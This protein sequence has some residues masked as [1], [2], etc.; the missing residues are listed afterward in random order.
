M[1]WLGQAV[2]NRMAQPVSMGA[3]NQLYAATATDVKG[4]D[5]IGPK[6]KNEQSG[7]PHKAD[8]SVAAKNAADAKRLW[9]VSEKLTGINYL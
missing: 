4:N 6:G 9:D 2:N 5:Y 8:R 7:Y 1:K 3:L